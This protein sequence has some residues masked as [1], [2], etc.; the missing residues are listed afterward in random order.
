[1]VQCILDLGLLPP[2][3]GSSST[4]RLTGDIGFFDEA[5]V[6][7]MMMMIVALTVHQLSQMLVHFPSKGY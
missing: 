1:M 6:P 4:I 7:K 3:S 5:F 2:L